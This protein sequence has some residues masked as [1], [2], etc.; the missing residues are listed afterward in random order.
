MI[1]TMRPKW[2]FDFVDALLLRRKK[3]EEEEEDD[4][5]CQNWQ[6]KE[7]LNLLT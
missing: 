2:K 1:L 4:S 7:K 3:V 5:S 6:K